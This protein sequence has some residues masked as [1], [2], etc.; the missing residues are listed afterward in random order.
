MQSDPKK[1]HYNPKLLLKGFCADNSLKLFVYDLKK[2]T[3][4]CQA[5]KEVASETNFYSLLING[6]LDKSLEAKFGAIESKAA[7]IIEKSKKASPLTNQEKQD[8]AEFISLM[9]IRT[10]SFLDNLGQ[11]RITFEE[12]KLY[13]GGQNLEFTQQR[14][15]EISRDIVLQDPFLQWYWKFLEGKILTMKWCLFK[16]APGDLL[17]VIT[18]CVQFSNFLTVIKMELALLMNLTIHLYGYTYLFLKNIVG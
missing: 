2:E 11:L 17:P 1:H 14:T 15:K 12:A 16:A 4:R 7:L 8:F 3:I 6:N 18:P 10:P 5:P 9:R 13:E